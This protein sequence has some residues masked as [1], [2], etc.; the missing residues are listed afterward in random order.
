MLKFKRLLLE[1]K[2]L[3]AVE[4]YFQLEFVDGEPLFACNVCDEGLASEAEI[5]NHFK[6]KH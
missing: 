1:K 5:E 4:D 3:F 2:K 6:E